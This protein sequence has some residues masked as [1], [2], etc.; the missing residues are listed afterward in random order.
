M[1]IEST[2]I[3]DKLIAIWEREV[4]E[5]DLTHDFDFVLEILKNQNSPPRILKMTVQV[6]ERFCTNYE[7]RSFI[8][9]GGFQSLIDLI[10]SSSEKPL[11]IMAAQ[12]V[13]RIAQAALKSD[14][15]GL[16]TAVD[17]LLQLDSIEPLVS[18]PLRDASESLKHI[19]STDENEDRV[20]D[21]TENEEGDKYDPEYA[22]EEAEEEGEETGRAAQEGEISL[23]MP[24]GGTNDELLK[25]LSSDMHD[26]LKAILSQMDELR[27]LEIRGRL[28]NFFLP[29]ITAPDVSV[30]F[31]NFDYFVCLFFIISLIILS[32]FHHSQFA[33]ICVWVLCR[34]KSC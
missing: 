2:G 1:S 11:R 15:D 26:T 31:C 4:D 23:G 19:L 10:R 18:R 25:S 5:G 21:D 3:Q 12:S 24:F 27:W 6:I 8:K 20:H 17:D 22:D 29:N 32:F 14:A 30:I 7:F 9:D 16:L 34:F 13:S 28:K 33:S